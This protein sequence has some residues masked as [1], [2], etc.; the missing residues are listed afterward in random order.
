M[1]KVQKE[2]FFNEQDIIER[3]IE[4][5]WNKRSAD[6]SRVRRQELNG[7]NGQAWLEL[8]ESHL[9][10]SKPLKVLD[11]GT[12]AGFFAILLAGRG[13]KV[14]GID[15]SPK[16]IHEA[17]RNMVEFGCRVDFKQ[18][19][20]Q[21]LNFDDESFDV[22]L[23]RNLTWTLP[24]VMQAYR[25][26]HRVL[27]VGGVLMNFDSDYGDKNFQNETTCAKGG[28]EDDMLAECTSIKNELRISTHTRPE[29]DID[30]LKSLGF[31]IDCTFDISST[32]QKDKI[33]YDP[34]PL[35]AIFAEKN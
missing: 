3:R 33:D 5:Y 16:M 15:M 18:M 11:V 10:N 21:E 2:N 32:V 19:N 17:K 9:K 30:F 8:I 6:F 31:K 7:A 12:G 1:F 20:A 27:K 29:W 35:F 24:D 23:S 25:E 22:L 28:V 14:T 4:N 34:V 26:W 13:H